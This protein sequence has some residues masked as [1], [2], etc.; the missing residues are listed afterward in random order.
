MDA[1]AG[2]RKASTFRYSLDVNNSQKQSGVRGH[3]K[4]AREVHMKTSHFESEIAH[5]AVK[6]AQMR[7]ERT[8][9]EPATPVLN[10]AERNASIGSIATLAAKGWSARKIAHCARQF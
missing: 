1:L 9:C 7:D 5:G 4:P 8:Q 2:L 6:A 3:S 10:P